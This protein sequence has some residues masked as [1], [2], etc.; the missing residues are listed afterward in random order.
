[1]RNNSALFM[2]CIVAVECDLNY[3]NFHFSYQENSLLTRP[4]PH[5]TGMRQ[6]SQAPPF[7]VS[8]LKQTMLSAPA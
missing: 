7:Y 3:I 1:M 8:L 6:T 2:Q 5:T 4:K